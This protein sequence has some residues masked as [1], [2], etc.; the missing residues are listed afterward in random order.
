MGT[1]KLRKAL[2]IKNRVAGE[3]SALNARIGYNNHLTSDGKTPEYDIKELL[4]QRK[5]V[6]VKLVAVKTAIAKANVPIYEKVSQIA[7]LKSEITTLQHLN[8]HQIP[9]NKMVVLEG[10]PQ[11][12]SVERAPIVTAKEVDA[13]VKALNLEIE[14]LQDAI[15]Y[16]NS[17]TEVVVPE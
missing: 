2:Q 16:H 10:R 8:T 1:V 14:A 3:L 4:K 15:D 6:Q 17:V 5:E 11:Y 12:V 7:E 9:E 13:A